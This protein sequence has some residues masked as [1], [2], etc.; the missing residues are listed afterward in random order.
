MGQL[1]FSPV[2]K[3]HRRHVSQISSCSGRFAS[4]FE[5][6]GVFLNVFPGETRIIHQNRCFSR[7]FG[8]VW[9][10]ALSLFFQDRPPRIQKKN[11]FREP[12]RESALFGLRFAQ[13]LLIK[14]EKNCVEKM[15]PATSS[16]HE[17]PEFA[18]GFRQAPGRSVAK[19]CL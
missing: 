15:T 13:Q 7:H 16:G 5:K 19:E 14:H 4:Q 8:G 9:G 3:P 6:E 18:G 10:C 2:L 12:T 17:D 11:L 1:A